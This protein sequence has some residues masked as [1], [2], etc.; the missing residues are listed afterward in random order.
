MMKS[1]S[2]FLAVSL[3]LLLSACTL[4]EGQESQSQT[5]PTTSPDTPSPTLDTINQDA[6]PDSTPT[7]QA[8]TGDQ[9]CQPGSVALALIIDPEIL[10]GIRPGL[11][12]FEE[13]LQQQG[14]IVIEESNEFTKPVDLRLYLADLYT[15]TDKCLTGVYLIGDVP[16]AYQWFRVEY[17]NPDIPPSEQEVISLS[18]LCRSGWHFRDLRRVHLAWQSRIFLRYTRG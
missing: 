6:E 10:D 3:L 18:V 17:A 2:I 8:A 9:G 11:T 7:D 1:K 12:Q 5:L 14:F 15:S 13:D 4:P 16:Y